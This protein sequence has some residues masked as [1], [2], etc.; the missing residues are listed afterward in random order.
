MADER[1]ILDIMADMMDDTD[2]I[3]ASFL[4]F[5]DERARQ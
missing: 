2:R 5:K 3:V 1:G 4:N